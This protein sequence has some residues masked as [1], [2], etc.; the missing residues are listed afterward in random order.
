MALDIKPRLVRAPTPTIATSKPRRRQ[1][2]FET[3]IFVLMLLMLLAV[4]LVMV[5]A[6]THPNGLFG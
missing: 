4:V 5:F 3:A 1:S 6:V 2:P